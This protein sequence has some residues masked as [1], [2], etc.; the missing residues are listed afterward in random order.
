MTCCFKHTPFCPVYCV[1]S[2]A[3]FKP[4]LKNNILETSYAPMHRVFWDNDAEIIFNLPYEYISLWQQSFNFSSNLKT[5]YTWWGYFGFQSKL[6]FITS[7]LYIP[8]FERFNILKILITSLF[9]DFN[10]NIFKT[11]SFVNSTAFG[12]LKNWW[13]LNICCY[14]AHEKRLVGS[15]ESNLLLMFA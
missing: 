5:C 15:N 10:L 8:H 9:F 6:L 1:F 12:T 14:T 13:N 3:I 7:I 11:F 4:F 2:G